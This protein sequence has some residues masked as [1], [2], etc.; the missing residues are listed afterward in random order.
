MPFWLQGPP[1]VST[2]ISFPPTH[3]WLMLGERRW[4]P[5]RCNHLKWMVNEAEEETGCEY[6]TPTAPTGKR[7]PAMEGGWVKHQKNWS[8]IYIYTHFLLKTSQWFQVVQSQPPNHQVSMHATQRNTTN[9]WVFKAGIH[10]SSEVN[11]AECGKPCDGASTTMEERCC[12]PTFRAERLLWRI[13]GCWL[14]ALNL[15]RFFWS[16]IVGKS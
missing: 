2:G 12:L 7:I 8:V 5:I 11:M 4:R 6:V 14:S 13:C 10:L 3:S 1:R 9:L 16:Q 15:R